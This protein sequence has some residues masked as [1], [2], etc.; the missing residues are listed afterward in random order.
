[1]LCVWISFYIKA[2][3]FDNWSL[4]FIVDF[5][6]V[7]CFISCSFQHFSKICKIMLVFFLYIF[8]YQKMFD[9]CKKF[10]L[11]FIDCQRQMNLTF[12]SRHVLFCMDLLLLKPNCEDLHVIRFW[13]IAC[14]LIACPLQYACHDALPF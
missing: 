4:I 3:I 12:S 11:C 9:H 1:M 5:N 14:N 13:Y 7:V 8:C 10:S 2:C 6:I